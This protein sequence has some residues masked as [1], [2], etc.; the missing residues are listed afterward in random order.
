MNFVLRVLASAIRKMPGTEALSQLRI[1]A[2]RY[3]L[4]RIA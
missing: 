2:N 4:C 3:F 1:F